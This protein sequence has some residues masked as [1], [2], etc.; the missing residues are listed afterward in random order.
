MIVPK[1]TSD[2]VAPIRAREHHGRRGPWT[3]AA[4]LKTPVIV[5]HSDSQRSVLCN[6]RVYCHCG[7]TIAMGSDY[8][9]TCHSKQ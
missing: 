3:V 5:G 6:Q 4:A 1:T 9:D 7:A 2:W 8:C